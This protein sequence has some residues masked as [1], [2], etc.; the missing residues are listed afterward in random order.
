MAI[1]NFTFTRNPGIKVSVATQIDGLVTADSDLTLFGSIGSVAGTAVLGSASY[2]QN[3][4][5]P[6]AAKAEC[7]LLFGAGAQLTEM[8][9]AA[10]KANLFTDLATKTFPKLK[11]VPM[12]NASTSAGLAAVLAPLIAIPMPF[13]V[14]PYP[15]TDAAA[16]TAI[17]NHVTAINANDR[18]DNGQFGSFAFL[19]TD[20][21][22][23]VASPAGLSAASEAIVIPYLRDLATTKANKI[24]AV[25]AAYAAVCAG[26]GLPFLPIN[27][28]KIGGLVAPVSAVDYLTAGDAGSIALSMDSGLAPMKVSVGGDVL[29]VRSITTRRPVSSVTEVAY[30]DV[31]DWQV[32]YY[33][34]K[35]CYVIAS[36]PRYKQ[37]KATVG[38][39]QALKSE[40]IQICKSMEALTMLQFVDKFAG[41][42]TVDRAPTNR[43]AALYKVPVNVVPILANLGI[44]LVGTT[45]YDSIVS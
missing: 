8:V 16:L 17:K 33:L 41:D 20:A 24:H 25:A 29:A 42:F 44:A 31:Q 23:A 45:Q 1:P 39:L 32:L 28:A 38:K 26:N 9:V 18:G 19:A 37:A 6:V 15:A 10:I 14:L 11:V 43:N 3:Y 30:Y 7:D 12:A 4:G 27:D 5:D 40:L 36:Q 34:R 2:I 13:I 21:D 35:N 22:V